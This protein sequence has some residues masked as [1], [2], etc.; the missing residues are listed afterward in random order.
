MFCSLLEETSLTDAGHFDIGFFNLV[1][2]SFS[3]TAVIHYVEKEWEA[4]FFLEG[5]IH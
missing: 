3:L 1:N 4:L 5:E 2:V